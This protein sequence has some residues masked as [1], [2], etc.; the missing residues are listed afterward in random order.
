MIIK[1]KTQIF[2]ALLVLN[3]FLFQSCATIGRG[4]YQKIP[5]TSNPS[6]AKVIVEEE[7]M[8]YTPLNLTLKRKKGHIIRIERQG[9]NPVVINTTR[10]T[11]S[12][13]VMMLV[14][15]NALLSI[16]TALL[17]LYISYPLGL[18]ESEEQY[19][20]GGIGLIAGL[21]GPLVIDIN[22]GAYYNL[23][24]QELNVILTKIEGQPQPTFIFITAEN[25]LDIKWIRIKC[26]DSDREDENVNLDN[27]D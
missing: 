13:G 17:G 23:S 14:Y 8:G 19:V 26:D 4:T 12:S 2:L 11:S 16:G 7:E 9:Y 6:G 5:V 24:P 10:A 25:F 1:R 20:M 18:D 15:G 27:S 22:S 21:I 3:V